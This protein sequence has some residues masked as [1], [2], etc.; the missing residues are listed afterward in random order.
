MGLSRA[1]KNLAHKLA[2]G[3]ID[4]GGNLINKFT[5]AESVPKMM[6]D[7]YD[8]QRQESMNRRERRMNDKKMGY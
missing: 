3:I 8:K 1:S 7:M 4:V 2:A 5:G 6:G